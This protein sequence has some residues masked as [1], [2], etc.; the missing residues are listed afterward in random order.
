MLGDRVGEVADLGDRSPQP[1]GGELGE[2]PAALPVGVHRDPHLPSLTGGTDVSPALALFLRG[3]RYPSACP[4][5]PVKPSS[6][7]LLGMQA[8]TR[9][10]PRAARSLSGRGPAL[11]RLPAAPPTRR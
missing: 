5:G 11:S 2:P 7:R 4:A 3:P 6:Q 1:G 9:S 8:I 10:G